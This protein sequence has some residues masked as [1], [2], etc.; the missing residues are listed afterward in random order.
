M[1]SE[2]ASQNF[3]CVD[4]FLDGE[5]VKPVVLAEKRLGRLNETKYKRS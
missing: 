2:N 3:R 5:I 1:I 4:L